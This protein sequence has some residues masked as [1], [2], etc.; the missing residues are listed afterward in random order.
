MSSQPKV[1]IVDYGMG[2]LFSV[3]HACDHVGID[4]ELTTSSEAVRAADAAI[5]PGV[6]AFGDAMSTLRTLGMVDALRE[7]AEEGKPIFGICLGLQLLMTESYEFGTHPGLGLVEGTVE[8][9]GEPHD[10]QR[11]LKVPQLGWNSLYRSGE[12]DP[13]ADTWLRGQRD[14]VPMYFVHSYYVKPADDATRIATTRYGDVEFCSAVKYRN[15]FACQCHPERSGPDGL[16][17][18]EEFARD[19]RRR[20]GVEEE[21]P[22]V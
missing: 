2:N 8:F 20:S 7:V 21:S 14:G 10:G 12:G 19:L 16:R 17:V 1:A 13:W 6:G 5:V 4:A 3:K 9:F 22:D 18:Y 11:R 15:V